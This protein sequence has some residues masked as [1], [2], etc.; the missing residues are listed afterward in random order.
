MASYCTPDEV[1][2]YIGGATPPRLNE[3]G[4]PELSS[5]TITRRIDAVASRIN[6][7]AAILGYSLPSSEPSPMTN[8]WLLLELLNVELVIAQTIRGL[9]GIIDPLLARQARKQMEFAEARLRFFDLDKLRCAFQSTLITTAL[10]T[11][12]DIAQ[13]TPGLVISATSKPTQTVAERIILRETAFIRALIELNGYDQTPSD[14]SEID[15]WK[16]LTAKTCRAYILRINS[17][18]QYGPALDTTV[19]GLLDESAAQLG[20]VVRG[21]VRMTAA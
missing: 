19:N 8:R 13:E 9:S 16:D 15:F 20:L 21:Q 1:L 6:N 18:S 11:V 12:A 5:T 3:T 2:S 17:S 7:R 14:Q 10:C 4:Q